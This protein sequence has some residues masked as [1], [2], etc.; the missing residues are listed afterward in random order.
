MMASSSGRNKGTSAALFVSKQGQLQMHQDDAGTEV[1][2]EP[3]R[4]TGPALVAANSA[5]SAAR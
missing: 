4:A 3:E 2:E 5:S 1:P